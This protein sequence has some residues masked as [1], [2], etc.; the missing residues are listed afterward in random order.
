V[1]CVCRCSPLCAARPPDPTPFPYTTL[2]RSR[3]ARP[4]AGGQHEGIMQARCRRKSRAEAPFLRGNAQR[5]RIAARARNLC[6]KPDEHARS[7]EHTSELQSR[8]K[9]VCRLLLEKKKEIVN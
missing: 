6:G 9:L 8:E 4:G 7:E 1:P 2:F 5:V 3:G